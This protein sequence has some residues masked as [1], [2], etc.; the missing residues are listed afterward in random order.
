MSKARR[1]TEA[2]VSRFKAPPAGR[3][4]EHYDSVVPGLA[5]R[6]TDKGR[7]SWSYLFR[8]NGRQRRLTIGRYPQVSLVDAREEARQAYIDAGKGVDAAA[9]K[10]RARR[11]PPNSFEAAAELFITEHVSG[12]RPRSREEYGRA[13]RKILIPEW[14]AWALSDISR[15]DIR[16]LRD[17]V[18]ERRGPIAANRTLTVLKVLL[19]WCI[20]EELLD[21]SPATRIKPAVKEPPRERVLTDDELAAVW[22]AAEGIGYPHGPL[23]QLLALLGQRRGE[24][25]TMRWDDLDLDE[26]VWR[27]SSEQTKAA[28]QHIV[29]LSVRAKEVLEAIPRIDGSDL[30]LIS[31]TGAAVASFSTAKKKLDE[32]SGV[33]H[34]RVHDLRRTLA[35][36]LRGLRFDR[37]VVGA[38]LNHKPQGVT[39]RTY[40]QYDQLDEKRAALEAWARHVDRLVRRQDGAEVV[41][42]GARRDG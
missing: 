27:L 35:T 10:Q 41:E 39:A 15:G 38:V 36:G 5:L 14:G 18:H 30:V 1:L 34:W 9:E 3:R 24:V 8:I 17:K 42:L 6:V 4:E 25:A 21:A 13:L 33:E 26:G 32:L 37:D 28:R 7:K 20:D 31:R 29:P 22:A 23:I 12:L 2:A 16:S 19:N 11:A 40:D